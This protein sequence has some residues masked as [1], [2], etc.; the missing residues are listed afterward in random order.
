MTDVL[1]LYSNM[2]ILLHN[3]DFTTLPLQ[4]HHTKTRLKII[5]VAIPKEELVGGAYNRSFGM[6]LICKRLLQLTK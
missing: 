6:T 1:V 5:V 3:E 4:L 2:K